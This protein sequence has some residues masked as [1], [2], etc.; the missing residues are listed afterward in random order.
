MAVHMEFVIDE[1]ARGEVHLQAFVFAML[2]H[3]NLQ[4]QV[5]YSQRGLVNIY[6]II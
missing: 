1:T 4:F 3:L 2:I 5:T 6:W